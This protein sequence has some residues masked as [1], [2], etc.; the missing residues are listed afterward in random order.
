MFFFVNNSIAT[1]SPRGH[2]V[3]YRYDFERHFC[4]E[5]VRYFH[6]IVFFVMCTVNIVEKS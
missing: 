2:A 4:E 3:V 1:F 5:T 6:I